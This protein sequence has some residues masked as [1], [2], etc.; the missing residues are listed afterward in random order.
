[1][2]CKVGHCAAAAYHKLAVFI[3]VP[4]CVCA[5]GALCY[6]NI[7]KAAYS[8]VNTVC[9]CIFLCIGALCYVKNYL[10][11]V[12]ECGY[13][14]KAHTLRYVY[15]FK[16][17]AVAH[18]VCADAGH[19]LGKNY[20]YYLRTIE[21]GEYAYAFES[22]TVLKLDCLDILTVC[23][24]IVA[25]SSDILTDNY[26]LDKVAEVCPRLCGMACKVGHCAAAAYHKLA[27]FIE[28]PLC[29][30]AAGAL[31]YGNIYKA[32]YSV[33]NTVCLCIFLCI[34]ALCYV[35]N[36]LCGVAECG[37]L[38]KAHTLRYVYTFKGKAV[39]HAVCADAG[40]GLGKNYAYYLRTIE[41]GEYAYAFKSATVL[42]VYAF[43]SLG[44][45]EI[46]I[47]DSSNI[48]AYNYLLDKM[49]VVCPRLLCVIGVIRH[50]TRTVDTESAVRIKLPSNSAVTVTAVCGIYVAC[51]GLVFNAVCYSV[52]LCYRVFNNADNKA[53]VCLYKD[54]DAEIGGRI[55]N[56]C[57]F[58][59]DIVLESVILDSGKLAALLNAEALERTALVER[60]LLKHL[61]ACGN[62]NGGKTPAVTKCAPAN[63]FKGRIL[64]KAYGF[65][66]C[67]LVESEF[68]YLGDTVTYNERGNGSC[69][70]L[71]NPG[72]VQTAGGIVL[73]NSIAVHLKGTVGEEYVLDIGAA[74]AC[75]NNACVI[76]VGKSTLLVEI[77]GVAQYIDLAAYGIA[78]CVIEVN[79]GEDGD[80][81]GGYLTC[82]EISVGGRAL[83]VIETVKTCLVLANALVAEVVVV[84]VYLVKTDKLNA[85][86][87]ILIALG[88]T[89]GDNHAV[90]I[91]LAIGMYTV[92]QSA[93][94]A[95]NHAVAKLIGMTRCVN[96]GAPICNGGTAF[97]IRSA[98]V[99]VFG[100]GGSLIIHS[101]CGMDVT[102]VP[103]I[104]ICK[105]VCSCC[106]ICLIGPHLGITE[107]SLT[108]EG[109]NRAVNSGKNAALYICDNGHSPELAHRL[110]LSVGKS[111]CALLGAVSVNV[112]GL[113][114]PYTYRKGGNSLFPCLSVLAHTG[115]LNNG[116]I[117]G[118]VNGVFRLKALCKGHMVKLPGAVVI[119]VDGNLNALNIFNSGSY[120]IHIVN[121]A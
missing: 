22:A 48:L 21:E 103:C 90:N 35:K 96:G 16:G 60:I 112:T 39:A 14:N 95:L 15:T 76:R 10:C 118:S 92:Q 84:A 13:L 37:Y 104:E 31:C 20:A 119:K 116:Y 30:C 57:S 46:I 99:A 97:T 69:I 65:E 106:H 63:C 50:S 27:V 34:G 19:G 59:T 47:A 101:L 53:C 79:L 2:A 98:G 102:A 107:N 36:Y 5:A 71:N 9:L 18:A 121:G 110:E 62:G 74:I 87:I 54:T 88:P 83:V 43:N 44:V 58:Y 24:R 73:H 17:K 26:L 51:S 72:R 67:I 8:V 28:V 3:E 56:I 25:D 45:G 93:A 6:G 61:N 82:G 78:I 1:M 77:A 29:V 100:T 115:D 109:G 52:I 91:G 49:T 68:T 4:L 70:I 111:L 80:F 66:M 11:G 113:E 42:K 117:L 108:G 33:V 41:E 64:F 89:V 23:K 55:G 7:Y 12:A 32:A 38:N 120:Q 105:T 86:H 94:V 75:I 85:V 114:R 40:H 81:A